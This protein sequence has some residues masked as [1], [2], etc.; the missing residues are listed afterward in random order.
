M[1]PESDPARVTGASRIDLSELNIPQTPEKRFEDLATQKLNHRLAEMQTKIDSQLKSDPDLRETVQRLRAQWI[2]PS[3]SSQ[4]RTNQLG[5]A[6]ASEATKLIQNEGP[7]FAD[8]S[9]ALL[10]TTLDPTD[11]RHYLENNLKDQMLRVVS[12]RLIYAVQSGNGETEAT[13]RNILTKAALSIDDLD[14]W[15]IAAGKNLA[16]DE[17]H[18][19]EATG[20]IKLDGS[21]PPRSTDFLRTIRNYSLASWGLGATLCTAAVA[22]GVLG[23]V[24]AGPAS[25]F[26][27]A[28]CMTNLLVQTFAERSFNRAFKATWDETRNQLSSSEPARAAAW[29]GVMAKL[30]QESS[31]VV[32]S[33]NSTS[34]WFGD[35][36]RAL[37]VQAVIGHLRLTAMGATEQ[38]FAPT[39]LRKEAYEYVTEL[40]TNLDL[41]QAGMD[42]LKKRWMGYWKMS[43]NVLVLSTAV[44]LG[45]AFILF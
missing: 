19:L 37:T 14:K 3:I 16:Q 30:I 23:I 31:P 44:S 20:L 38:M 12:Q 7:L 42:A 32:L 36:E 45:A 4:V 43:E 6:I 39:H 26:A 21:T 34:L 24:G 28:T 15:I 22:G 1:G 5:T 25:L 2:D 11:V 18:R 8:Y 41:A 35:S 40:Q 17:R 27:A 9:A 33:K 29:T 10:G 13:L